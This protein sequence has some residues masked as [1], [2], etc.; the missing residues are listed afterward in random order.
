MKVC[1]HRSPGTVANPSDQ[2]TLVGIGDELERRESTQKFLCRFLSQAR[3]RSERDK[4]LCSRIASKQTMPWLTVGRQYVYALQGCALVEEKSRRSFARQVQRQGRVA[5]RSQ[6]PT[7]SSYWRRSGNG[8]H[9][10]R[11]VLCCSCSCIVLMNAT[12]SAALPTGITG[13]R[14]SLLT[15]VCA[16]RY[17]AAGTTWS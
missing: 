8:F 9:V 5:S 14:N 15:R 13:T 11:G 1:V 2:R 17:L 10:V 12:T 16:R 7:I 3:D 6:A 4:D